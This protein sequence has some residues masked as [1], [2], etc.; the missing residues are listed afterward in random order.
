MN[1]AANSFKEMLSTSP[2]ITGIFI[3]AFA[4]SVLKAAWRSITSLGTAV[5]SSIPDSI[6]G[7]SGGEKDDG[8]GGD[9]DGVVDD[10]WKD[11]CMMVYLYIL[12]I[13]LLIINQLVQLCITCVEDMIIAFHCAHSWPRLKRC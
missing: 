10:A 13:I 5:L 4:D 9:G 11:K 1:K 8:G 3:A 12:I 2:W 6:D 7:D